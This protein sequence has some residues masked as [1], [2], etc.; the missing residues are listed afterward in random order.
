MHI[1]TCSEMIVKRRVFEGIREELY[2]CDN[3][4]QLLYV[5]QILRGYR[6]IIAYVNIATHHDATKNAFCVQSISTNSMDM[7]IWDRIKREFGAIYIS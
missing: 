7:G 4:G 2:I 5:T 1:S 3:I 6:V